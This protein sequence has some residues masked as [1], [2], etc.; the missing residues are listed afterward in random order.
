M[1]GKIVLVT[2]VTR[3][4]GLAMVGEF[5]RLGHIVLG[6]GRTKKDIES[7]RRQFGAPHEFYVVDVASDDEVKSWASI[8]L[9][10]RGVPDL[11]VNNAGV[12][13]KF[14]RLWETSE[15]EFSLVLDINLKSA[16]NVV[17]HFAP[18]MVARKSG[19]FV[20][21]SSS[22]GRSTQAEI[23]PYC[24][25]KWGLE[26]MTLALAQELPSGMAAIS[27]NPGVVNTPMLQSCL[28]KSAESYISAVE[29][30]KVAVPFL[31]GLGP[32]DN[33]KQLKVPLNN[34]PGH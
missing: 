9:T 12:I 19:V 11:V 28:G 4:L 25:S 26:G 30:A 8:L 29:W 23:G 15:W 6:C 17:R 21:I 24:A 14:A 34:K 1:P 22:W 13:N 3:G 16:A 7:L 32:A 5:A 27:V 18:E 10:S 33:G 2:G 20:N 31:L